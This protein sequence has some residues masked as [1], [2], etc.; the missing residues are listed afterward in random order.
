LEQEEMVVLGVAAA[1][2]L[3]LIVDLVVQEM[4]Q[5]SV[6]LKAIMVEMVQMQV[7]ILQAVVAVVQVLLVEMQPHHQE[8]LEMAALALHQQFL[9]HQ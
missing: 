4:F 6:H 8:F 7:A 2:D 5:L 9:V 1:Q 3:E